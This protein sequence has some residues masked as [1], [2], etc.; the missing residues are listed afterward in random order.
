MVDVSPAPEEL[1]LRVSFTGLLY[2]VMT[3]KRNQHGAHEYLLDTLG[4]VGVGDMTVSIFWTCHIAF[5]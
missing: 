3:W 2:K 1:F 5:T 4:E